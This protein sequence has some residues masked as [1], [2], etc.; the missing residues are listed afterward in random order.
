MHRRASAA[1]RILRRERLATLPT[2][3]S[4]QFLMQRAEA[5]GRVD[6]PCSCIA[7]GTRCWRSKTFQSRAAC[8]DGT[9]KER[10]Q[11]EP[12]R[13]GVEAHAGRRSGQLVSGSLDSPCG[14]RWCRTY[15]SWCWAGLYTRLA[16]DYS[17]VS[18]W[19]GDEKQK[20]VTRTDK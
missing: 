3:V 7:V 9:L 14:S 4:K 2:A 15:R 1:A 10:R 17:P 19:H 16:C 8:H 13:N 11:V 6:G 18:T 20:L 12:T 5:R